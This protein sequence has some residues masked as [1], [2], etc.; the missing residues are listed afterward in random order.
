[1]IKWMVLII[2]LMVPAGALA[3]S[4]GTA[5]A[6]TEAPQVDLFER[7]FAAGSEA[8]TA[9]DF[10][11]A[12]TLFQKAHAARPEATALYNAAKAAQK[13]GN[14]S[15]ALSLSKDAAASEKYPLP[16]VL[17]KK[18]GALQEELRAQIEE[19]KAREAAAAKK[20]LD[21][22]GWSG[23]AAAA[24]GLTGI[25]V[26][27]QVY[28]PKASEAADRARNAE[29]FENYQRHVDDQEAAQRTGW[30]FVYSGSALVLIGAGL[31]T[32]DLLDSPE[33]VSVS[34]G[35]GGPV[36]SSGAFLRVNF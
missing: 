3:Q 18:N 30:T 11:R 24:V 19:K 34:V 1:M 23:V 8:Y 33:T 36:G 2:V 7:L 6:E 4:E 22:R 16:S 29:F 20:G 17:E 9:G 26:G 5:E 13:M 10:S 28:G 31:V 12:A 21:A 32:W 25:L 35:P 14:L 27:T 15:Q